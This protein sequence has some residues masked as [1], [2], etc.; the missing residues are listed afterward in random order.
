MKRLIALV[1]AACL[2]AGCAGGVRPTDP[3]P[4]TTQAPTTMPP[5]TTA[6]PETV[7]PETVPPETEPIDP[8]A[9]KLAQMTLEE[10][11]GQL[12]LVRPEALAGEYQGV[13]DATLA[14][15]ETYPVGGFVLFAQNIT[16]PEQ[17]KSYNAAL[18]QT[19]DIPPFLAVDEEGG[20]VARLANH[21]AF[22]LPRY[23]SAAAVGARGDRADGL[24]MGYTI[25]GYLREYGFNVN[26]AP[27]ADVNTNPNNPVIGTRAFSSDPE[28]A[29]QLADA[30]SAALKTKGIIPVFKHFP[31]H[32]D[33]AQDSHVGLA[34]TYKTAEEMAQCEWLPFQKADAD[35]WIMVAHVAAPAI[36]GDLTP[37][38]LSSKIVT[39]ILRE[40][41]GFAGLVVTDA[42]EM[43]A[44]T[45]AYGTGQAAVEALKAGCDILLMPAS[46]AEAFEAVVAAVESGE[47]SQARLDEA[48]ERIL[49]CKLDSGIWNERGI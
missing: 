11:V 30:V 3:A 34:V 31:G 21:Y 28:T 29:A 12:F 37:A 19:G 16:G 41:L 39:E 35:D 32:G 48:V 1:C 43:G 47:I 15:L 42:L 46:L 20:T 24:E 23:R 10:K 5:E 27:V 13:G 40:E 44:I 36:T 8:V 49:R 22:D 45:S 17:L 14:A 38:T 6:P 25:G 4:A 33:T 18:A 7:P 2:L 26:F 9:E